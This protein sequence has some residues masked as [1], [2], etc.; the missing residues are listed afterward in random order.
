MQQ[1]RHNVAWVQACLSQLMLS[2]AA[3][4]QWW[5]LSGSLMKNVH[6]ISTKQ[7]RG[8]KLGVLQFKNWTI[9]EAVCAGALSCWKVSKSS[10][11]HKCVKVIV[12]GDFCGRNAKNFNSLSSVNQ[13]KFTIDAGQLFSYCQHWLPQASLY[14]QHIMTSY[15]FTTS[16]KCLTNSYIL[17][18]YFESVFL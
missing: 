3:L 5:T 10:Y 2:V 4:L 15:Y 7:D 8:I 13:M 17:F 1:W 12:L 16:K 6:R 9:S 18:K 11:P 14:S